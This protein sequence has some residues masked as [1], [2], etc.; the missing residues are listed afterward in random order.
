MIGSAAGYLDNGI[1]EVFI[2]QK[3]GVAMNGNYTSNY[4]NTFIG[5]HSGS[6]WSSGIQN[7]FI[8]RVADSGSTNCTGNNNTFVGYNAAEAVEMGVANN[9]CIGSFACYGLTT[10]PDTMVGTRLDSAPQL[11]PII[12][13]LVIRLD[14]KRRWR[15]QY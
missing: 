10:S 14:L 6:C 8:G 2:G 11:A 15:Q 1:D 13:L 9:S 5:T 4:N 3:A 12:P 7:V